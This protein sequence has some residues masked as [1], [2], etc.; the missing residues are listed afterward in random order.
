MGSIGDVSPLLNISKHLQEYFTEIKE[1]SE[2]PQ[3]IGEFLKIFEIKI[4]NDQT[5]D[6]LRNLEEFNDKLIECVEYLRDNEYGIGKMAKQNLSRTAEQSYRVKFEN[7]QILFNIY[8]SYYKSL[9]R[10]IINAL[11]KVSGGK[12]NVRELLSNVTDTKL[13]DYYT[14]LISTSSGKNANFIFNMMRLELEIQM[15]KYNYDIKQFVYVPNYNSMSTDF[16]SKLPIGNNIIINRIMKKNAIYKTPKSD[17]KDYYSKCLCDGDLLFKTRD[18]YPH[19]F[20]NDTDDFS[21]EFDEKKL[22]GFV[23]SIVNFG[24]YNSLGSAK[25]VTQLKVF[26]CIQRGSV[27]RELYMDAFEKYKLCKIILQKHVPVAGTLTL[28]FTVLDTKV[29]TVYK[30]K[31]VDVKIDSGGF[32]A[33]I[34]KCKGK[35]DLKDIYYI[36]KNIVYKHYKFT[37]DNINQSTKTIVNNIC[38]LSAKY[39]MQ[40]LK[41]V[42]KQ[43]AENYHELFMNSF[44]H[45]E[46]T[47]RLVVLENLI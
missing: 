47:S 32:A 31:I 12:L 30:N 22:V 37:E 43:G 5:L 42:G 10:D 8:N 11:V 4:S 14:Q 23:D 33:E 7:I 3:K 6:T 19:K 44:L 27:Y 45:G 16:I 35:C 21:V 9:K 13:I 36:V 20:I 34:K 25:Q 26:E 38:I 46:D 17:F 40:H 41:H 18:T 39:I 29:M 2:N 24:D 15:K 28:D 1:I